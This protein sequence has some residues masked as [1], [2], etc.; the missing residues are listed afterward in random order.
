MASEEK[1]ASFAL[2]YLSSSHFVGSEEVRLT[3]WSSS[4]SRELRCI[5]LLSGLFHLTV[6]VTFTSAFSLHLLAGG[7]RRSQRW[8]PQGAQQEGS[9]LYQTALQTR[10]AVCSVASVTI[11]PSDAEA[12]A[13]RNLPRDAL[14]LCCRSP[15]LR[16]LFA[17]F[18]LLFWVDEISAARTTQQPAAK[19][20]K[21]AIDPGWSLS[22]LIRHLVG[23][24]GAGSNFALQTLTY[25]E[26]RGRVSCRL[27]VLHC[28]AA[29]SC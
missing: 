19:K 21:R 29:E 22:V 4:R 6:S 23:R 1:N 17:L 20:K 9:G 8:A 5:V 2:W 25:G 10:W 24:E 16:Q 3:S 28:A 18:A 13:G 11:T 7:W 12:A 27:C 26:R 14:W 15:W